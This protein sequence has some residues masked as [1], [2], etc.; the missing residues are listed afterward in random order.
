MDMTEA[1]GIA[2]LRHNLSHHL[3]RVESR[4]PFLLTDRNRPVAELGPAPITGEA[5]D[6]LI[7]PDALHD[8]VAVGCHR[9]WP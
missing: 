3:R 4:E 7:A 1:V 8:P 2:E 5:L 6:R 9:R